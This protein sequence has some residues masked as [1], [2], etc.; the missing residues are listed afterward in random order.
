MTKPPR[1]PLKRELPLASKTYEE[2]VQV[3]AVLDEARLTAEM[4]LVL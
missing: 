3:G 2:M 4:K 1:Y